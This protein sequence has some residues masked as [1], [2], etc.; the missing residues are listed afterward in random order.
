MISEH[1]ERLV[2]RLNE[3]DALPVDQRPVDY[4]DITYNLARAI[5]R[6]DSP[7]YR[8]LMA[9]GLAMKMSEEN[10][11]QELSQKD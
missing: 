9:A 5:D 8:M 10:N 11:S 1:Q 4:W 3:L 2:K 7:A 6:I